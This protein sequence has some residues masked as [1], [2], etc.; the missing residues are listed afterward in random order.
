MTE[1]DTSLASRLAR[2]RQIIRYYQAGLVNMCFG[3]GAFSALIMLGINA[4]PAQ[5]ISHT[6]GVFFNYFVYKRHVFSDSRPSKWKFV[7]SYIGN[8]VL[9]LIALIAMKKIIHNDYIAGLTGLIILSV[10]NFCVLKYIVFFKDDR[11]QN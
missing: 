3:Y 9:S 8:Y 7:V 4:Y 5:A 11:V 6:I 1:Q 10:F 2:W